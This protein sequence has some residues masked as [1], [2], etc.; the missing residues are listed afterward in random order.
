MRSQPNGEAELI[1]SAAK[2]AIAVSV[3][4]SKVAQIVGL[5]GVDLPLLHHA[6]VRCWLVGGLAAN[7]A[8]ILNK[9]WTHIN[10][11]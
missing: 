1:G 6:I 8:A 3:T 9:A 5:N 7:F 4:S 10:G 11:Q 2:S